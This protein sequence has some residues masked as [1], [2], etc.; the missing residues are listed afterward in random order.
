M[1]PPVGV[2]VGSVNFTNLGITVKEAV[3]KTPDVVISYGKFIQTIIDFVIV[4]FTIFM[5]IRAINSLQR[6]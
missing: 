5:G 4:A 1:I 6:K 3:G 2:L